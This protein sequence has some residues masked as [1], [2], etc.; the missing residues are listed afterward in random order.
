MGDPVDGTVLLN[1]PFDR[2][3]ITRAR[4]DIAGCASGAGLAGLRLE[5][6]V[7]AVNEIMT[8]AVRHGGGHGV[9]HLWRTRGGLRCQIRDWGKGAPPSKFNGFALPPSSATGGRGLWLARHLCDTFAVDSG[10]TGTTV[11]LTMS[12]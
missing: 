1:L 5:G 4:H 9:A 11:V 6:F 3:A 12:I 7:L 8:N 10:R 2:D